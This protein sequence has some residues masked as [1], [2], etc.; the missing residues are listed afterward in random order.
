MMFLVTMPTLRWRTWRHYL[1]GQLLLS[2]S[3]LLQQN[4]RAQGPSIKHLRLT[5]THM[6]RTEGLGL[7]S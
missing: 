7:T 2:R 4:P 3:G 6:G 1:A 5:Y